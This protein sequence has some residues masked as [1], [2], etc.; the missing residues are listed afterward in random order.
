MNVAVAEPS[1]AEREFARLLATDLAT[2]EPEDLSGDFL[3]LQFT[4]SAYMRCCQIGLYDAEAALGSLRLALMSASCLPWDEEPTPLL[5]ADPK[6][7]LINL[8]HYIYGLLGRA[9]AHSGLER[10]AMV[11]QAIGAW[12]ELSV[13]G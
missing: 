2:F 7:R 12:S 3:A 4:L 13:A 6:S 9:A 10:S 11:E 5:F 8:C 1:V